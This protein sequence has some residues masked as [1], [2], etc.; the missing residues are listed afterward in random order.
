MNNNDFN[1]AFY[2][3]LKRALF[4]SEK[5]HREGSLALE[6]HVDEEKFCQRGIFEYGLRFVI[7]A[8]FDT[9]LLDKILSNIIKQEKD[10]AKALLKTIQKEAI[11]SIQE[12]IPPRGLAIILNSYTDIPL[13]DPVFKKI[14]NDD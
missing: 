4:L 1:Q 13:S 7:D 3:I 12:G 11:L 14:L 6:E 8:S 2:E 5:A 10:E 9:P